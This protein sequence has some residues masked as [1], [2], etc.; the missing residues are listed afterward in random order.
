MLWRRLDPPGH[1]CARLRRLDDGGWELAGSA[2]FSHAGVPCALSY[3]LLCDAAWQTRSAAIEGWAGDGAVQVLV[4]SSEGHWRLNG[5]E[6]PAVEGCVDLDLSFSP[7]TNLLPLRRLA[8]RVGEGA[9]V[10]AAWLR[11]PGL[12]LE[13]LEQTYH[14]LSS[15][16]YRYQSAGGAFERELRVNEEGWVVDY[17]GLWV[18]ER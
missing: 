3:R 17:P 2:V 13:P 11:F 8:L 10:R 12:T 7:C 14:R 15:T 6:A 5:G 18:A 9:P 16:R 4:S 1:D